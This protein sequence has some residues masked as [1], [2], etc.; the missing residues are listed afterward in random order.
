MPIRIIQF[1][2]L[3]FRTGC[4]RRDLSIAILR[5]FANKKERFIN[6][7]ESLY[8]FVNYPAGS[9]Y[10]VYVSKPSAGCAN[11]VPYFHN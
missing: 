11:V 10:R 1:Q 6:D 4:D 5:R 3:T 9:R 2:K 7:L 8:T